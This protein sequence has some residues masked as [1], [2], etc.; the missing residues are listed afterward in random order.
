MF[1][2][3]IGRFFDAPTP[4]A[5][6]VELDTEI[7]DCRLLLPARPFCSTPCTPDVCTADEVCTKYPVPLSVGALAIDGFGSPLMLQAATTMQVYQSPSLPY[8]PCTEGAPV[9]ASAEGFALEAE[10]IAP[11]ELTGPDPIPVNAG[12]PV[13]VTWAAPQSST[14]SRI[15]V[16]LDISHHGGTKGEIQCD[17]PDTGSLEIPEPLVTKLV[18]LGLQLPPPATP[19]S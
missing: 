12:E 17:A 11:L 7:G 9:S 19:A 16:G 1:P 5:F 3:V 8:P 15:R 2:L 14:S 4:S 18:E 10:C 13:Q 6:P